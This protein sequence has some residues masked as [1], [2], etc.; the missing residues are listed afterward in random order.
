MN[1]PSLMA[2]NPEK[3]V[4]QWFFGSKTSRRE[5]IQEAK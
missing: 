5:W 1:G 4:D 2:F 3:A